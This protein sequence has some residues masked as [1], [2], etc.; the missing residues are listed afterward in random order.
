MDTNTFND[1]VNHQI[2]LSTS[3]LIKKAGEY[4]T[5]DDRLHNFR[6]AAALRETTMRDALGGMMLK[7]T[8]S[9]YDL[10]NMKHVPSEEYVEEKLGDHINYLLL[11]KAVL[12]EERAEER[13]AVMTEPLA[14][15]EKDLLRSNK[16]DENNEDLSAGAQPGWYR[17]P[18]E[19]DVPSVPVGLE[20]V[21]ETAMYNKA[22]TLLE[23]GYVRMQPD[24]V[25]E[26]VS[27][28]RKGVAT[29]HRRPGIYEKEN[30]PYR[31]LTDH[32]EIKAAIRGGWTWLADLPENEN[33]NH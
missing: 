32:D 18:D 20:R 29:F 33:T 2:E 8:V 19:Y 31:P 5:G 22:S 11:L 28:L 25:E 26:H 21:V 23:L 16:D 13:K 12:E 24:E 9:V 10:I 6:I 14:D 27:S 15:W 3:V 17:L 7:H 30:H 4:A 1:V